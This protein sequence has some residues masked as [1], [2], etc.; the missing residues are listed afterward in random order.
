MTSH[1]KGFLCLVWNCKACMG[2]EM[3]TKSI[4]S[5]PGF[6]ILHLYRRSCLV[7]S[8]L[9]IFWCW[10]DHM[11]CESSKDSFAGERSWEIF[12]IQNRVWNRVVWSRSKWHVPIFV[13]TLF[14]GAK[15]QARGKGQ[16]RQPRQRWLWHFI[17]RHAFVALQLLFSWWNVQAWDCREMNMLTFRVG[18]TF[19]KFDL[20]VCARIPEELQTWRRGKLV[21]RAILH[22][23]HITM[24]QS[25]PTFFLCISSWNKIQLND[26]PLVRFH[27]SSQKLTSLAL[28][29]LPVHEE[30]EC[31]ACFAQRCSLFFK[32]FELALL[33]AWCT[34]FFFRL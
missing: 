9:N 16:S 23:V 5:G 15:L 19:R 6:R 24:R 2:A 4:L 20:P 21:V 30:C 11:S 8:C 13:L 25:P 7:V 22:C 26:T 17:S 3:R 27:L 18:N 34:K 29:F 14:Q 28:L 10:R 33:K 12:V 1:G 32:L 31:K